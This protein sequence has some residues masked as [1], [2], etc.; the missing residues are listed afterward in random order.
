MN[1]PDSPC[2]EPSHYGA[3]AA[4]SLALS[5]ALSSC[6][7]TPDDDDDLTIWDEVPVGSLVV[8]EILANPNVSRPEFVEVQNASA[9]TVSLQGCQVA[10]GGSSAH[11]FVLNAP[12][13]LEPGQRA[14]L[15][16]EEFLGA[17]EGEIVPDAIWDGIVLNQGDEAE[18]FT[19]NC[20]DGIGG[21]QMIDTVS[22]DW[23]DLGVARGRSWQLAIDP[24]A[25]AND[26]PSNWCAAPAQSDVIYAVVDGVPDYG[27]P[28]ADTTCETLGGLA[29]TLAGDVVI[30]EIL[31]HEFDG[32][33]EW[34]ELH[35]PG[36]ETVDVRNCVLTDEALAGGSDPNTHTINYEA[37]G[38]IIEA[39]GFLLLSRTAA[40]I[41]DD[42]SLLADYPYSALSFTNTEAQRLS[43]DCPVGDTLVRIDETTYD[44]SERAS[45]YRG[46][47]LSLS[48]G[49]LDSEANDDPDSWC[50]GST[51]YFSTSTDDVPP[52]TLTAYGTPGTANPTCPEPGPYPAAGELV[53]TEL[54]IDVI[55]GVREWVELYNPGPTEL[56]LFGCDLVDVP[57]DE[58]A[59]NPETANRHRLTPE[60]G[61]TTIAGGG[62]LLLSKTGTDITDDG[63]VVADYT[64]SG[65]TL[66]NSDPQYLW[67]ECPTATGVLTVDQIEF[68]WDDYS[69]E[70]KG[71]SLSLSSSTY[72]ASANDLANNWCLA[73]SSDLYFSVTSTDV[74]PVTQ[75][76]HG[77][78]G[79]GNGA[80]L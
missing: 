46:H 78:P 75:E 68:D 5:V 47:S 51:S 48:S 56:D 33:R 57:V 24:D 15:S 38:T 63:A 60:G 4:L 28:G 34:F 27:S 77:T 25:T 35:N 61:T 22:F 45:L 16:G 67:L 66:N 79:T 18:S 31:I 30:S 42:G 41:T 71:S 70:D 59:A 72:T 9:A 64:Y 36:T 55:P 54:L 44:W 32:L 11:E 65:I 2:R 17:A 26:D 6:G 58:V 69:T 7:F 40:D 13:S 8:T 23:G 37:G 53:I 1:V 76:A 52:S 50:V 21:R 20:P 49:A 10:D 12:V 19:I 74:P 39:G 14:L 43:I 80:C 3:F 29:P 62:Y 73:Q